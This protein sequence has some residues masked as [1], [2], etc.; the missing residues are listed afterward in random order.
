MCVVE[1]YE[2]QVLLVLSGDGCGCPV[3]D[4]DGEEKRKKRKKN[5]REEGNLKASQSVIEGCAEVAA[6][7]GPG[8]ASWRSEKVLCQMQVFRKCRS[9]LR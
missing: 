1:L 6:G 9:E 4:A 5:R 2:K 7:A 8:C 3:V